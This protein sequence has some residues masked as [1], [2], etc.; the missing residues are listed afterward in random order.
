MRLIVRFVFV[1]VGC[2]AGALPVLSNPTE[3]LFSGRKATDSALF[4]VKYDQ[5]KKRSRRVAPKDPGDGHSKADSKQ[6]VHGK[7]ESVIQWHSKAWTRAEDDW[8]RRNPKDC[9]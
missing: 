1:V 7:F 8:C 9:G 2:V 3:L 6:E 5:T 4:A